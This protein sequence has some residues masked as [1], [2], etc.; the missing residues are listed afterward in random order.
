MTHEI[1]ED[2]F[3]PVAVPG[4]QG[5]GWFV[6]R[7]QNSAVLVEFYRD[8][9]KLG[10]LRSHETS[11]MLWAGRTTVFEP[12][13]LKGGA[14]ELFETVRDAPF[15]PIFRSRDIPVTLARLASG[16]VDANSPIKVDGEK[17]Y[18]R[19]PGGNIFGIMPVQSEAVERDAER[20]GRHALEQAALQKPADDLVDLFILEMR[21]AHPELVVKWYTEVIG[22]SV[23]DH[24]GPDR[25]RLALGDGTFLDIQHGGSPR[26]SVV[27]DREYATHVPVF[28]T[29]GLDDLTS[30]MRAAGTT[31]VQTVDLKGGRIWYGLD[32][33]GTFVGFQER[34][35]PD[36]D[37]SNWTKRLIEDRVARRIWKVK[38]PLQPD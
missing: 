37:A 32:P 7:S 21:T 13:I 11:A 5:V 38:K 34:R 27:S 26:V 1:P 3:V 25:V 18:F 8:I 22:L 19:D 31:R 30:R 20:D 14:A 28:R 16:G 4:I 6:V 29:Y 24:S 35:M 17:R 10:D 23:L 33:D 9:L 15:I 12:N 2:D 36:R